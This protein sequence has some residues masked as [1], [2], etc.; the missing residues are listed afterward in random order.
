LVSSVEEEVAGGDRLGW[1]RFRPCRLRSTEPLLEEQEEVGELL[2]V[3]ATGGLLREAVRRGVEEVVVVGGCCCCGGGGVARACLRG[4]LSTWPD[5]RR[6]NLSLVVVVVEQEGSLVVVGREVSCLA[7]LSGGLEEEEE[8][9]AAPPL[10]AETSLTR[11]TWVG[12]VRPSSGSV[13]R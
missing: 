13:G 12:M 7:S 11:I 2:E 3:W 10:G 5:C 1:R 6:R 4:L 9:E 8:E